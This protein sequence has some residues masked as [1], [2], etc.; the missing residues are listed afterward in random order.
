[1]ADRTSNAYLKVWGEAEILEIPMNGGS[2]VTGY[3]G[4]PLMF[5]ANVDADAAVVFDSNVTAAAGDAFVGIAAEGFSISAD[6]ADGDVEVKA[7]V[8]GSI[9]GFPSSVFDLADVGETV[10]MDDS[11]TLSK[12]GTGNLKIGECFWVSGGYVYVR[13]F[14][15]YQL[16]SSDVA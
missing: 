12:T 10:Y 3:K 11:G 14:A 5:D 9:I 16:T 2:A 1:M 13:I 7:Y 4:V 6:D 8:R 15:P